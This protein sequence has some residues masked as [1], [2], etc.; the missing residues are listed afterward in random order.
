LQQGM[1][2]RQ[3]AEALGGDRSVDSLRATIKIVR[4]KLEVGGMAAGGDAI[5]G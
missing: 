2:P 5:C 1:S 3:V 4:D